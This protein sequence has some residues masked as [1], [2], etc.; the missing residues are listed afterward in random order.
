MAAPATERT[1]PS[2]TVGAQR[3]VQMDGSKL[4]R[5]GARPPLGQYLRDMWS[6][7]HF[8][9]YDS[10]SRTSSQNSMDN[11][12]RF[13]MVMNPILQA[14]VYLTVFGYILETHR[15]ITN[16][17]GYLII[18][19]FTFRFIQA[20]VTSASNSIAGNQNV[21]Q[22]FNFPRAVLPISSTVRELFATV[23]TF[24][25]M[26]ILVYF[27]GDLQIGDMVREPITLSWHWLLFF[28]AI[29][30]ALLFM[31]GLGLIMARLVNAYNDVKNLVSIGTRIW[32][33]TS[34]VIF[35][36]DRFADRGHDWI[37]W[38]MYHN[39]AFCVLDIIR[40]AWIYDG[41]ADP[42][43]WIVLAAWAFGGLA[44]GF[45][46]FWQGEETYGRER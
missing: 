34:A 39:P 7:R 13:W 6:F 23:P 35:G 12:G 4:A 8:L 41:F 38:L 27:L 19:V 28:P 24:V 25:V 18:G 31:A 26:A 32:F 46:V 22:A 45:I 11:L 36:V 30:L 21:V 17:I 9:I 15:G 20:S 3:V 1:A 5:V 37:M 43:R 40:H 10:H 33:Y 2:F 44:V 29:F 14:L 42:Y 16:F